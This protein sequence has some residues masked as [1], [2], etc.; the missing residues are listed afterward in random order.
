MKHNGPGTLRI[1]LLSYPAL[2]DFVVVVF[3]AK[4][5]GENYRL[6]V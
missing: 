2:P 5:E 4:I 6:K 1:N 3:G